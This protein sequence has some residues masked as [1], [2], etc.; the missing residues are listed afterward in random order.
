M[1]PSYEVQARPV[2]HSQRFFI[3]QSTY[4]S[5]GLKSPVKPVAWNFFILRSLFSDGFADNKNIY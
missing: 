1:N 4:W 3:T 5:D 2:A